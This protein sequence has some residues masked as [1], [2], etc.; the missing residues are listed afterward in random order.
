MAPD[1]K[2]EIAT[3]R[4]TAALVLAA[5]ALAACSPGQGS[6]QPEEDPRFVGLEA[7][8][9]AWRNDIEKTSPLCAAKV[10][11]KGCEAFE[12]GCKGERVITPEEQARGVTA[13]IVTAMTFAARSSDGASGKPGS[14]FAEFT[15]TGD[16]W[17]R[18]ETAPVNLST[19]AES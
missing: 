14:A 18:A 12:V 15:R 2:P 5:L 10:K 13:K 11:G 1:S 6:T 8:I 16:A 7:Q 17:T 9:L 3:L 19:C 4:L